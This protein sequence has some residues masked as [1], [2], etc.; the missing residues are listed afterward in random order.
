M[1]NE[2]VSAVATGVM[3]VA[4]ESAKAGTPWWLIVLGVVGFVSVLTTFGNALFV[5]GMALITVCVKAYALVKYLIT[6]KI[7]G[8]E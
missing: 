3:T 4:I 2:T 1:L 5:G 8:G 6:K 7:G